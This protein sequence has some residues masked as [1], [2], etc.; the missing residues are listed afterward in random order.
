MTRRPDWRVR[1]SSY[2]DD[3]RRRPMDL[4]RHDCALFAAGAVRAM[5]GTDH[6]DGLRGTYGTMAGGLRRVRKAG[7]IDHVDM[8]AGL[9]TEVRPA[10][11]AQIGDIAVVE[12]EGAPSL[13]IVGGPRIFVLRPAGLVTLDLAVIQRAFRV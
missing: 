13:G 3:C 5:T 8:V 6:A 2:I 10:I 7:Y 12:G 1:L 9:F 4:G 11:M